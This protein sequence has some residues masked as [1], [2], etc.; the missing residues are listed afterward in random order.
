MSSRFSIFPSK[1]LEEIIKI[2][3]HQTTYQFI[4]FGMVRLMYRFAKHTF[5]PVCGPRWFPG[6]NHRWHGRNIFVEVRMFGVDVRQ[7]DGDQVFDHGVGCGQAS[8]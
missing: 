4:L 3:K 1:A 8:S 6:F 2:Q 5:R 7:F